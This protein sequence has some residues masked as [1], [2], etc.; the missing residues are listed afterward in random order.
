MKA[1]KI[2]LQILT[3]AIAVLISLWIGG[4]TLLMLALMGATV[5]NFT[6]PWQGYV[7]MIFLFLVALAVVFCVCFLAKKI[8][9]KLNK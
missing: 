1:F 4:A 7:S 5:S 2:F 9:V 3:G 8:I 6:D